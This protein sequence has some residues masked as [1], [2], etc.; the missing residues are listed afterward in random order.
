MKKL[1]S[2]IVKKFNKRIL[3]IHPSLLPHYGGK[4]FYGKKVHQAVINAGETKTGATV[5]FVDNHYDSGPIL[6]QEEVSIYKK[7]N[8]H[9]IAKRVLD[10]EHRIYP[11]AIKY[12]C[13][14]EIYWK[15]K[16]PFI[17]RDR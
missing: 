5:H 4:G 17:K 1:S 12:F 6:I 11:K 7:D 3:N 8:Y 2:V 13:D 14:E 9:D 10:V 16:K 15:N